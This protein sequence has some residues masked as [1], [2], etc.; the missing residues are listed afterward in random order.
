M[1]TLPLFMT[2]QSI[3]SGKLINGESGE[4]LVGASIVLSG[5][6]NGTITDNEGKFELSSENPLPW[7]IDISYIGYKSLSYTVNNAGDLGTIELLPGISIDFDIIVTASRKTEKVTDS[8]ASISVLSSDKIQTLAQSGEPLELIK[9]ING[10]Q[11]NQ[12]GINRANITLRGASGVNQTTAQVLKDYRPLINPGDYYLATARS[13]ISDIDLERVEVIRG[14]AGALYGPGVS[15]GVVHFLSKDPFRYPGTTISLSAGERS[16]FKA[17]VRHANHNEKGTFGYKLTAGYARGNDWTLNETDKAAENGGARYADKFVSE[18]GEELDIPGNLIEDF[19]SLFVEGTF[20]LRPKDNMSLVWVTSM[21]ENKGNDR[22]T[23]DD[24]Y[25]YWRVWN[26]QIRFT[27]DNFFA[28]IN[29]QITPNS[30]GSI[31]SPGYTGQYSEV[32]GG[33]AILY[34]DGDQYYL[35]AQLQYG[36]STPAINTEFTLGGDYKSSI[37]NGNIRNAGRFHEDD[38]YNIYGAYLQTNTELVTDKL[39]LVTATRFDGFSAF[40]KT[41][42]SPRIGLVLKPDPTSQIRASY[43]RSF[44]PSGQV[45]AFLDFTFAT[46]PWGKIQVLGSHAPITFNNPVTDFFPGFIPDGFPGVGSNLNPIFQFISNGPL[47]GAGLPTE[48]LAYLQGQSI[49]GTTDGAMNVFAGGQVGPPVQNLKDLE[50]DAAELTIT[51][52]FELGYKGII[53]EKLIV[54]ADLYFMKLKDFESNAIGVSPFVSLPNLPQDLMGAILS[55]L[56]AEE[57]ASLGGDINQIA[58]IYANIASEALGGPVGAVQTDQ[59]QEVEGTQVN[60][61]FQNIGNLSYWGMDLGVEYHI[62]P[63]LSTYINYGYLSQNVFSAE[64]IGEVSGGFNLNTPQDKFRIGINYFTPEGLTGGLHF[65]YDSEFQATNGI[66]SGIAQSRS[67][68]D[69]NIGYSFNNGLKL[70]LNVSNLLDNKYQAFPR[71]PEIGR[72]GMVNATYSF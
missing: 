23:L 71:L 16:V 47:A 14:P 18:N 50:T 65:L 30:D 46:T 56:D 26:N 69:L 43:N 13:T 54:N 9:Q 59:G 17:N 67:I 40:D 22:I 8:P 55:G 15:A 3:I 63:K 57:I 12:Q 21:A 27:Y 4:P 58:N 42:F 51:Q 39:D 60:L 52:A 6:N 28:A 37:M 49:N 32:P 10:V 66:Y 64:D 2:A 33:E 38:D 48:L 29:Y 45:R 20:E 62:S 7:T 11:L 41:G 68:V 36:F 31:D 25:R 34:P 53:G 35:D 72:L 61:G 44:T 70:S 1:F 5:T 19:S 24:M